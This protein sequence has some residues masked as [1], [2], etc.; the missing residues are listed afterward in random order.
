MLTPF[1]ALLGT[2]AA[3]VMVTG[4][5]G[6]A[7]FG[8]LLVLNSAIGI[9]QELRAKR[10]LDRLAVLS[11]P[12]ARVVRNGSMSEIAV[13]DVV[14]DD[15]V[16]FRPGD[17]VP[18]DCCVRH[19]DGLEIDESLVTGESDPVAKQPGDAVLSGSTV[20]AGSGTAQVTAV[21]AD[22]FANR[23]TDEAREFSLVRSELTD[24]INRIL[25]YVAISLAVVGPILFISQ[26]STTSSWQ[27]AVRGAVAGLVGMVPEG[28]VLLTSVT[29]FAAALSL[30]RRRVLVRELP[31]VEGLARIDMLCLDKTGTLTEGQIA[32]TGVEP[33]GTSPCEVDEALAALAED[34]AGNATVV[35]LRQVFPT[36]PGWE[37]L[38]A[39]PF[40]SARKWSATSFD[41]HGTWVLGAPEIVL[42]GAPA[43]DHVRRRV[44]TLA[45]AGTRTLLLARSNA[46]LPV[47][48]SDPGDASFLSQP[49]ELTLPP[50]LVAISLVTFE[51]C[52]RADAADTL[53]YFTAQGVSLKIISGD[54][55]ATVGAI[56]RRVHLPGTAEPMDARDLPT[57]PAELAAVL[58][59]RAV[60][61]RVTPQQKRSIVNG[62]QSLGHVVA[63]T[64]DGVN[65]TLAL[66][67]ADIGV[68]MGSGTPASRAVAQ[69]VLLDSEFSVLPGVVAEGR[70]VI[71]N[72]ERVANL[73]LTKNVMSLVLA[74]AVAVARW[75]F[76]FL[77]RHLTL[78]STVVI[79]VP[80][81]FLA[82]GPST[83]RFTPGFVPRVLKFAIPSGVIAAIAVFI[84]YG[85]ARDANNNLAQSKTAATIV[86]FLVSLWVLAIQARPMRPW[87]M[88]LVAA[89]GG[90]GALA[91]A[92]PV[93]RQFYDLRLPSALIALAACAL[94]A[95]A[96]VALEV[97]CRWTLP[98]RENPASG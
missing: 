40:S 58:D 76:P 81:F 11:D 24:G 13:D 83:Q 27:D 74:L 19:V 66:K 73:F 47:P 86:L 78:V 23:L 5:V 22:S 70:R 97:L 60:F 16:E 62:L 50:D 7:L 17:Q 91:F 37:K 36:P 79:G 92:L 71:A 14:L 61:G 56:A 80:G 96:A 29:F 15:L 67:D 51:E 59:Q 38:A 31:A 44:E 45:A 89:M 3:L 21:G 69:L 41:G 75:P 52:V 8:L 25:K 30:A 84:T 1:N 90:L 35:A 65:D 43:D 53:G 98:A 68:A 49:I 28:L 94:A 85:L 48:S 12:R 77:P 63:M 87:K 18:A 57:D 34:R 33:F 88:G 93:G 32:F 46:P 95:A 20:I 4:A 6:D 10:T 2:L 55:P 42:A 39:V 54:N 82:L 72:V 64:G 9:I 26:S